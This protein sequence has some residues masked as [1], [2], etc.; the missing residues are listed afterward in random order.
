MMELDIQKMLTLST[1]H[2]KKTTPDYLESLNCPVCA[3]PKGDYGWFIFIGS[4]DEDYYEEVNIPE[5]LKAI[6][7]FAKAQECDWLCIDCDGLTT[8]QL[9]QYDW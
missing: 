6:I 3:F 7:V 9:P 1:A 5:D 4:Y 8:D 2:V